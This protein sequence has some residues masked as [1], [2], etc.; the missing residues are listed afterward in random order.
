M[1][2]LTH[3]EPRKAGPGRLLMSV[4]TVSAV[5]VGAAGIVA[6]QGQAA[7]PGHDGPT[8]RPLYEKFSTRR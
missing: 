7:P 8:P 3:D 4:A 1:T 6:A 5:V 2:N